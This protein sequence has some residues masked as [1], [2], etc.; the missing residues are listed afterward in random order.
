MP[1]HDWTRVTAGIW[2]DFHLSWIVELQRVL[3]TGLLP[4]DYYSQTEQRTVPQGSNVRKPQIPIAVADDPE[5]VHSVINRRTLVVRHS[6]ADQIVALIEIVSP[7]IRSLQHGI[8]S[9]VEQAVGAL[10]R[11]SHLLVIDLLP[12]GPLD[13]SGIHGAIWGEFGD[14]SFEMPAGEPLM[15]AAYTA[16]P[17]SEAY[18]EPT[19]VGRELADMPVFLAPPDKYVMVPLE[20]TYQA[21]YRAV[22]RRWKDVLEAPST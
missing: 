5:M 10:Y 2:H 6:S 17:E 20:A 11:G 13:P 16:G 3:N 22:P 19:A 1:I 14:S 15:L 4:D 12:P 18:L 9:F 7:G 21:A 8:R